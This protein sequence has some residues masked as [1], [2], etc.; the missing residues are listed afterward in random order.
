MLSMM[1][2]DED[3]DKMKLLIDVDR[4]CPVV[5]WIIRAPLVRRLC[6]SLSSLFLSCNFCPL[7]PIKP[8]WARV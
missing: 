8:G 5:E 3:G 4:F 2:R 6:S 7:V 1:K